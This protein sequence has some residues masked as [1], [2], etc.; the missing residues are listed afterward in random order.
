MQDESYIPVLR[1]VLWISWSSHKN[2]DHQSTWFSVTR[3]SINGGL[4]E[5][6]A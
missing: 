2:A 5:V 3:K 6:M 4:D 1:H